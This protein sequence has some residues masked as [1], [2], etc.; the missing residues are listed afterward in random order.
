MRENSIAVCCMLIPAQ[1]GWAD[2][3]RRSRQ[4]AVQA[5]KARLQKDNSFVAAVLDQ[6]GFQSRGDGWD[7]DDPLEMGLKG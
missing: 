4:K 3:D 1:Q 6:K 7:H 2:S 5:L